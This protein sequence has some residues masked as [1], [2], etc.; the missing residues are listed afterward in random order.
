VIEIPNL[1]ET[2]NVITEARFDIAGI[3][4]SPPDLTS[5]TLEQ[6]QSVTFYWSIRPAE[7]GVYRGTIWLYLRFVDKSNGEESQK[8]VS[9]QTV[10][11]EAVNLFGPLCKLARQMAHRICCGDNLSASHFLRISLNFCLKGEKDTANK[12]MTKITQ[13]IDMRSMT[14]DCSLWYNFAAC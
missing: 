6:G 1:Y 8:A 12:N 11:I 4:V 7:V 5:Q 14:L 3:Q 2:H 9:A 13:K 10:E